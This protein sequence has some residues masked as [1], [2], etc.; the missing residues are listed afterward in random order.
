MLLGVRSSDEQYKVY[1][2]MPRALPTAFRSLVMSFVGARAR[3]L[4][5]GFSKHKA[6]CQIFESIL[7]ECGQYLLEGRNQLILMVHTDDYR[8]RVGYEALDPTALL[9]TMI[10]N[11]LGLSHTR[12]RLHITELYSE[13]MA[14]LVS[15]SFSRLPIALSCPFSPHLSSHPCAIIIAF[16]IFLLA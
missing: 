1:Y 15:C 16:Q 8:E 14:E 4:S 9:S 11:L 7:A 5:K 6:H 10:R 3:L 2:Q 12:G 13:Y